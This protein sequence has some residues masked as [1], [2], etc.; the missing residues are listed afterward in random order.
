MRLNVV[1]L[2]LLRE[3]GTLLN[4]SPKEALD[5]DRL[6]S[7]SGGRDVSLF[8]TVILVAI[9]LIFSLCFF[10]NSIPSSMKK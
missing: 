7:S 4:E 1:E 9:S 10:L 6:G 5:D 3:L 8:K 2:L